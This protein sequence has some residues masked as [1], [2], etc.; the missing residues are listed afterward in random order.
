MSTGDGEKYC[1][2]WNDF[3]TNLSSAFNEL[4]GDEDFFD[5]TLI[6]E[7]SEIRCHKLI[8]GACSPHFRN[9]IRRLSSVQNPA[10]YLRG[11][12]HEDIK[13]ILEF[14]YLGM[15]NV[16]QEDLDSFLSVAQ[17]LC[18]KGLTQ[19]GQQPS[20]SSSSVPPPSTSPGLKSTPPPA[21]RAKLKSNGDNVKSSVPSI[22]KKEPKMDV[23]MDP[24]CIQID[25]S[26]AD[27][28]QG[29]TMDGYEDYYEAGPSDPGAED[30]KG[31]VGDLVED[32]LEA[33][34]DQGKIKCLKC[35]KLYSTMTNARRHV[36]DAHIPHG[37]SQCQLCP[38]SFRNERYRTDHYRSFHGLKSD[39][40]SASLF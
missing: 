9:I 7:E 37:K 8:L 23:K 4:R 28:D 30:G 2:R 14:M 33:L 12:R 35:E 19:D 3:T 40:I 21:K 5:I 13:N 15:V 22:P 20:N 24:D 16:A 38:R 34:P 10:I 29:D 31:L 32:I 1:L 36:K 11:V 26:P 17:D 27:D 6:T 18:I 39:C 25:E